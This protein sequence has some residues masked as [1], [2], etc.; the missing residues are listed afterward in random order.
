MWRPNQKNFQRAAI[1]CILEEFKFTIFKVTGRSPSFRGRGCAH[2]I[3][4]ERS[5]RS[6]CRMTP[7]L[8]TIFSSDELARVI[9]NDDDPESLKYRKRGCCSA[10]RSVDHNGCRRPTKRL[11]G[12]YG[13]ELFRA[14]SFWYFHIIQL[15]GWIAPDRHQL[16]WAGTLKV[17][18]RTGH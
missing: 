10:G 3:C 6:S 11:P 18:Q 17:I 8:Q 2:T 16:Y 14:H 12:V 13:R 15:A 9:V 1:S 7:S 5:R 4:R